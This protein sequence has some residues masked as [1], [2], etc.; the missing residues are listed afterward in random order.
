VAELELALL[1]FPLD[2]ALPALAEVTGSEGARVLGACLS[3]GRAEAGVERPASVTIAGCEL[4]H[5]KPF[6]RAVLGVRVALQSPRGVTSERTVY[7]KLFADDHGA[8]CFRTLTALWRATRGTTCLRVPEPLGY[9]AAHR[10]L[11]MAEAPGRRDLTEWIG[12][13]ENGEPLPA[14][15]DLERLKRCALVAARALQELQASDV[16]PELRRT[17]A[18]ELARVRKDGDLLLPDLHLA[19][20][21]LA[22]R[23]AALIE[24]LEGLAP[25]KERLVPAHGGYR[26]KQ[27]I[28]DEL[29]LTLIDWDGI[30]LANPALDAATFLARL[31]R[32][33][34]RRPGSAPELVQMAATFRRAFLERQPVLERDLD[35]H[36]ALVLAEQLLRALR[37][38]GDAAEMAREIRFL[39]AAASGLLEKVELR[40]TGN[41]R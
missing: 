38:G 39:C 8:E 29:T 31:M 18:H 27:M 3:A 4:V 40:S 35:L 12:R 30:S 20:P 37:R 10:M 23:A 16:R 1:F 25:A 41:G 22:M 6:D 9:D 34:R 13:L 26:H 11:L 21:E 19:Q 24:R 17:F 33:P 15:V 2:P 5:Y 7:A 36:E 32:E 14:G 28:G